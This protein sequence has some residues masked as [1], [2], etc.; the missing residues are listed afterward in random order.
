MM[1]WRLILPFLILPLAALGDDGLPSV[2]R[3]EAWFTGSLASTGAN[4]LPAGH[5]LAE[6]YV[7]G[8]GLALKSPSAGLVPAVEYNFTAFTGLIVGVQLP[9]WQSTTPRLIVPLA[10]L[11]CVF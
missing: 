1:I 8:S 5:F 6:P 11:N 3:D 2:V 7:G 9:V 4:A 10:A